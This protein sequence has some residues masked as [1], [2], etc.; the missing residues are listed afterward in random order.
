M[1]VRFSGKKLIFL[2]AAVSA[3]VVIFV[4]VNYKLYLGE[5]VGLVRGKL[6][7]VLSLL[8][9]AAMFPLLTIWPFVNDKWKM[10]ANTI[11]FFCMP[12]LSLQ[13]VE[14]FNQKYIWHFMFKT[15]LAN[16]MIILVLYLACWLITGRF[17]LTGLIV[18]SFLYVFAL[19]S[20][21]LEQFRGIPL[22]PSDLA[23]IRTGLNVADNYFFVLTWNILL[24]SVLFVLICLIN[25]HS[26]GIRPEKMRFKVLSK[27]LAGAYLAVVVLTF[28]FTD[29][30]ANTGYTPDFWNQSRGYHTTGSFLNFCLNTK[31]LAARKPTGYDPDAV[32][33][34]LDDELEAVGVDPDGDTSL[35]ILTGENDYEPFLVDGQHPNIIFIMNESFSDLR[36]LGDLETN[37]D[38]MPF[39]DSLTENTIRGY[40]TVPVFA[41]GTSNSEFEALTGDTITSLPLGSNI[42]QLY[43]KQELPSMVSTVNSLDYTSVALHPYY[44][45]G[46]NRDKV[47]PLMGFSEFVTLEDIVD[48]DI[49]EEYES[50]QN[51]NE[52]RRNLI[53]RYYPYG[54][55]MLLRRFISDSYDFDLIEQIDRETDD[56]LFLFNV[57][58]Q[59]HGS[60]N[61]SYTG[62]DECI[63]IT[64]MEGDYDKTERYLSL[65][66]ATDDAVEQLV[67]YYENSTEPTIICMFGDHLPALE[68]AFYEEIYG[69]SMDDLNAEQE[70]VR[71]QTPFFIWANYD[72]E[73]AQ[74]D[75]I[76]SNYLSVLIEQAA[77]LPMTQYEK[78]LAA[79]YQ[80]L[81]VISTVGYVD[82][83][84]VYYPSSGST[85]YDDL[86]YEYSCIEYNSLLDKTDR[87]NDLFYLDESAG[88]GDN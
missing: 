85:P 9:G 45:N 18:N 20:S 71:Y 61:Y 74:V 79:L 21:V 40:V 59:N 48:A 31:Y 47:Y 1:H 41:T 4:A 10:L 54:A 28:Y 34:Y 35:N 46:W 11:M 50:T 80:T 39:I 83:E 29:I 16:Y 72:I 53:E 58:M 19:A 38:F 49:L 26:T 7:F 69:S 81:P 3:F 82:S 51:A 6:L 27:S 36:N 64:N 55:G 75:H 52:Y 87:Q 13:M 12:V 44:A 22:V 37:E 24:G 23:S 76:S 66:K 2:A 63:E 5:D 56:P 17:R 43:L 73:D 62:F 15:G 70:Q 86:L 33:G 65:I 78:Y 77:G 67:R 88:S 30:S 8:G 60:Y 14:S 84:G 57:T 32:T 42:Y 25:Q 68:T